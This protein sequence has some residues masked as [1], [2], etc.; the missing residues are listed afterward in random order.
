MDTYVKL[1]NGSIIRVS[2]IS[3]VGNI[4]KN[5][6]LYDKEYNY[7]LPLILKGSN[8]S[9]QFKKCENAK[10]ARKRLIEILMRDGVIK[11]LL[12]EVL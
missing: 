3:Y 10:N 12:L 7:I 1:V 5:Y 9:I 4:E 6:D 8:F 11:D 2:D